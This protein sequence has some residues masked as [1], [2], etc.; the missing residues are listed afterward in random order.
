MTLCP[1]PSNGS[2]RA[3]RDLEGIHAPAGVTFADPARRPSADGPALG[4][5]IN[6]Q[7]TGWSLGLEHQDDIRANFQS[8]TVALK[9][10]IR[11]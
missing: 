1:A 3:I 9:A 7:F 11:F 4:A 6:A 2:P 5:G 10:N 8:H